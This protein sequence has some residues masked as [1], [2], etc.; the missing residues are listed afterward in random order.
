MKVAVKAKLLRHER[1][2]VETR[3]HPHLFPSP[4]HNPTPTVTHGNHTTL[5]RSRSTAPQ[6]HPTPAQGTLECALVAGCSRRGPRIRGRRRCRR[7]GGAAFAR[8]SVSYDLV[9]SIHYWLDMWT[10]Q[11]KARLNTTY[12]TVILE[13]EPLLRLDGIVVARRVV[14]ETCPTHGD[15]KPVDS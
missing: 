6:R 14:E 4:T 13:G 2:T 12:A 15:D 9:D 11:Q 3:L 7:G 8:L 10:L 5:P 1:F